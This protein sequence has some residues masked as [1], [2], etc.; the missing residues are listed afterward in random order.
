MTEKKKLNPLNYTVGMGLF[1]LGILCVVAY[2]LFYPAISLWVLVYGLVIFLIG[3]LLC[4]TE[5]GPANEVIKQEKGLSFAGLISMGIAAV[6]IAS[7]AESIGLTVLI[8]VFLMMMG[9]WLL[10]KGLTRKNG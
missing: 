3:I 8:G 9:I 6:L 4:A 2:L 7:K 10:A 1:F 5:S